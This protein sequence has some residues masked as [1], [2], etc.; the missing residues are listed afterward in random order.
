MRSF[1][2]SC[3][4]ICY[5]RHEEIRDDSKTK[6]TVGEKIK[7]GVAETIKQ[8][9]ELKRALFSQIQCETRRRYS[10]QNCN[11]FSKVLCFT[12]TDN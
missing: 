8:H 9:Q 6:Q 7:T 2:D 10:E 4:H 3:F 12:Y 1:T 11:K 5:L